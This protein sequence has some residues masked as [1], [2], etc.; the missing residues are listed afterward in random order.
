[1]IG[2]HVD[3]T[4]S[5][6]FWVKCSVFGRIIGEIRRSGVCEADRSSVTNRYVCHRGVFNSVIVSRNVRKA[7]LQAVC[8]GRGPFPRR[9]QLLCPRTRSRLCKIGICTGLLLDEVDSVIIFLLLSLFH[10][11]YHCLMEV[12]PRFGRSRTNY[13]DI[14]VFVVIHTLLCLLLN[15]SFVIPV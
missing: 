1:M 11:R 8:R 13:F 10:R 15:L 9:L 4:K 5:V 6:W 12:F 2:T 7:G 3:G 14:S